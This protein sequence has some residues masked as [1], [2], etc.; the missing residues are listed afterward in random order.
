M[1][2][3]L[4][5]VVKIAF[6]SIRPKLVFVFLSNFWATFVNAKSNFWLFFFFL[7]TFEQ[8][9]EKLRDTFWK[10]SSNLWKALPHDTQALVS[11]SFTSGDWG[12]REHARQ[13]RIT[14]EGWWERASFF[15]PSNPAFHVPGSGSPNLVPRVLSY[16]PCGARQGWVGEN[17]GNEVAGPRDPRH[18]RFFG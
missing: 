8:L 4:T 15:S 2:R 11:A 3:N 17:H 12:T 16:P 13:A 10:I 5:F 7:T 14:R 9:F 1:L 18:P 6:F